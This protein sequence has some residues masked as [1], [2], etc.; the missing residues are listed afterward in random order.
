MLIVDDDPDMV[1]FL[2]ASLKPEGVRLH[3]VLNGAD[4][5]RAAHQLRPTLMLLDLNLPD[6]DGLEVCRALR[7]VDDRRLREMPIVVLTGARSGDVDLREAFQS[8]TT[9]FVTK[10][11]KPALVRA[12]VRGWLMR[13]RID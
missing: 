8:G 1:A 3:S 11:V 6:R 2:E 10:P 13:V 12:R 5:I 7:G 9:D 4:A